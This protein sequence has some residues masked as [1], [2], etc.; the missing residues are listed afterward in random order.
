MSNSGL[1]PNSTAEMCAEQFLEA[2]QN[3]DGG[4]AERVAFRCLR[5]DMTVEVLYAQ[6]IAPAMWR[7][8]ELWAA[9]EAT[10]ADEHLAAELAARVT[11]SVH[12]SSFRRSSPRWGTILLAGPR[13]ERHSLGLRMAADVLDLAGHRVLYLGPGVPVSAFLSMAEARR[14]DVVGLSSTY[15]TEAGEIEETVS[16]LRAVLP[17]TPVI[18]GGRLA[19]KPTGID[20]GVFTAVGLEGLVPLVDSLLARSAIPAFA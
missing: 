4:D 15:A 3:G 17:E 1:V 7:I 20:D 19:T 18:L 2:L 14:P 11:A 8:G 10:V 5:D 9:G 13:K 16:R 12:G 6:V